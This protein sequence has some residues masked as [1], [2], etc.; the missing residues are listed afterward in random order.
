M[1]E[2]K[3]QVEDNA[4]TPRKLV[5]YLLSKYD[6]YKVISI[7]NKRITTIQSFNMYGSLNQSSKTQKPSLEVPAMELPTSLLYMGFK[8][9]TKTTVI[10]SFDN[11]WQFS[12]RIHNA[13]E[14]VAA[15]LK[16]DI[17]IVGMP[18]AVNITFDCKW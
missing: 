6:F 14:K 2:V 10:M 18:P 4:D 15:S 9:K 7:D 11:G 3:K 5:E 12:F 13:E 8:P 16:F 1:Q 17:Q